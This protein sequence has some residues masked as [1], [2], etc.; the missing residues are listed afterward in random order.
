MLKY[1]SLN[2]QKTPVFLDYHD[3]V[4]KIVEWLDMGKTVFIHIKTP[5]KHK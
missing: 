5:P 3:L 1:I 2:F 4:G